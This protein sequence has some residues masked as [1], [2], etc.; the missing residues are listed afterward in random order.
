MLSR[1]TAALLVASI[2]LVGCTS[3]NE[4]GDQ[5]GAP[6]SQSAGPGSAIQQPRLPSGIPVA[7]DSKRVHPKVPTFS[8]PTDVTNPLFPVSEQHAVVFVG[9]VDDRPFRTEVTLLADTRP[10]LV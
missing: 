4:S 6:V 1:R 5:P 9:H 3:A 10:A 2:L 8:R 7:P